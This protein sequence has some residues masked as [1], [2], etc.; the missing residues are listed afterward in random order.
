M[1]CQSYNNPLLAANARLSVEGHTRTNTFPGHETLTIFQILIYSSLKIHLE[2]F[3]HTTVWHNLSISFHIKVE[4]KA[5]ISCVGR[6]QTQAYLF[7]SE[8]FFPDITINI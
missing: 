2:F 6:R 4:F 7:F 8:Y 3:Y 1:S 5:R